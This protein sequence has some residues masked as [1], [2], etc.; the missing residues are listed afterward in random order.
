MRFFARFTIASAFFLTLTGGGLLAQSAPWWETVPEN[1]S[2]AKYFL[3]SK[4]FYQPRTYPHSRL[5]VEQYQTALEKERRKATPPSES[6]VWTPIGP[7]Q[8]FQNGIVSHWQ[9]V[10]GRA[11]ALAVDRHLGTRGHSPFTA[12]AGAAAGGIWKTDN[13]AAGTP[14]RPIGE[15]LQSLTF[16]AIA[17]DPVNTD[18]VYAGTGEARLGAGNNTYEG[19]G[20]FRSFDGGENWI[21]ITNGFGNIT[22]FAALA[23]S[24]FD[25]RV[26]LAALGSGNSSR[27]ALSNEGIW[28]SADFGIT[29]TQVIGRPDGFDVLAFPDIQDTQRNRWMFAAI[30]GSRSDSSGF[31]RSADLGATWEYIRTGLPPSDEIGR[32]QIAIAESDPSILYA[33][34]FANGIGTKVFRS[35]D[36]GSSWSQISVGVELGGFDGFKWRDQGGYDLCIAVNPENPN[37]VLLGNVELHQTLDGQNFSPVRVPPGVNSWQSP[38]HVDY[39]RIVFS[40][41]PGQVFVGSD[42]GVFVGNNILGIPSWETRNPG[43][44]TLQFY[45]LASSPFNPNHMVGG[46]QDNG[47][48]HTRDGGSTWTLSSTGDGMECF[49]D[50]AVADVVYGST[51]NGGLKRSNDGGLS[52]FSIE[53]GLPPDSIQPRAWTA[54]FFMDAVTR[55][56]LYTATDRPYF[57]NNQGG[58]WAP[59]AT[60]GLDSILGQRA[61]HNMAQSPVA[62]QNFALSSTQ[63]LYL[64]TDG[65]QTWLDRDNNLPDRWISR[66][67]WD[68]NQS[69]VL[70][71]VFS[72]F[73]TTGYIF[74][75]NDFGQNWTNL[76]GN[77]PAVPHNDLFIHPE[78]PGVLYAANDFGVYESLDDGAT[79]FRQGGRW[80]GDMPFVPVLDFSYQES[81]RLLRA[82]THGRS[83]FQTQLGNAAAAS[84]TWQGSIGTWHDPANWDP[85]GIPEFLDN[86][87]INSGNVSIDT[88]TRIAGLSLG[89]GATIS[90]TD[91]LTVTANLFWTHGSMSGA[92]VTVLD[93]GATAMLSSSAQKTLD[94]TFVN[95]GTV[96]WTEGQIGTYNDRGSV[97]LNLGRLRISGEGQFGFREGILNNL[98]TLEK[99]GTGNIIIRTEL[100][101]NR[102]EVTI[103]DGTLRL[104]AALEDSAGA[105]YLGPSADLRIQENIHYFTNSAFNGSGTI[106]LAGGQTFFEG[107]GFFLP[108]DITLRIS[109]SATLEGNAPLRIEGTLDWQQGTMRGSGTTTLAP[110]ATFLMHTS[111]QKSLH[112]NLVN[113]TVCQWSGGHIGTNTNF[114]ANFINEGTLEISGDGRFGFSAGNL[115]NHGTIMKTSPVQT[116]VSPAQFTNNGEVVV[117]QGIFELYENTNGGGNYQLA[118]GTTLLMERGTHTFNGNGIGGNGH[119]ELRN[120]GIMVVNGAGLTLPPG[121]SLVFDGFF[122]EGDGPLVIEGNF[123]WQEGT[124]RGSGTTTLAPQAT[125]LLSGSS[126]KTLYRNLVNQTVCQ[127]S[128]G[129]IGTNAGFPANFINEG[130]LEISGNGRFGFSAGNLINH[131]T[132][133]K[134][135]GTGITTMELNLIN[136]GNLAI[137]SGTI[138]IAIA[139]NNESSGTIRG[140]GILSPV[141]NSFVNEGTVSP[142]TSPGIL[143]V[144]GTYPQGPSAVLDI[145]IGGYVPGTA[146]D[147]LTISSVAQLSGLLRVRFINGFTPATG[148]TFEVMTWG[149]HTGQF[150]AIDGPA[151]V[152]IQADYR[153][154]GLMLT[155]G[156]V[157]GSAP[158]AQPDFVTLEEDRGDS[159]NVLRND[160]DP[161]GDPL[162]IIS[163]TQPVHGSLSQAGDSLLHYRPAQNFFGTDSFF[164][165]IGDGITGTAQARVLATVI[166]VND[167]PEAAALL[168][169]QSGDTLA[170][171][172]EPLLFSWGAARDVENDPVTYQLFIFEDQSDTL[173]SAISDTFAYFGG[174]GFLE[175]NRHYRWTVLSGDG[176]LVT[177]SDTAIF[178]T[179]RI[180]SLADP[181]SPLPEVLSLLQNYPNPFNPETT[182][183]FVLP[184]AERVRLAVFDILGRRVATLVNGIRPP[185][186]HSVKWDGRDDFG[187]PVASGIY[188][189]RIRAA[190]FVQTRK[191]LLVW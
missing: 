177:A 144:N 52:F 191:M 161:D 18:T 147:R 184:Q 170:S 122:L 185:G 107:P 77:L 15:D 101:F 25:R 136:Q 58:N 114:P 6:V 75:S 143:T 155:I 162:S 119:I 178:Y 31:Y 138:A 50:P 53:N 132:I 127:W 57:S 66:L 36:Y 131:G 12:Y 17:I 38:V 83:A 94:R 37:H 22:H 117:Q 156:T 72:G 82:A 174:E 51:Q 35:D 112:R 97:F 100:F 113:Q 64:S 116:R 9:S 140:S 27:G 54:P 61:V 139:L 62:P 164:Y 158:L 67:V 102:G 29:W 150:S 148:D 159:I 56:R 176:Q 59:F 74:R 126:Q 169:P 183:G 45:R 98:G 11:R 106:N 88:P 152:G 190:G 7:D 133:R 1:V 153:P 87:I 60:T 19:R 160:L 5:P 84:Y 175:L 49:Y 95:R 90:G 85:A 154:T 80:G 4:N 181:D 33:V 8:I 135:G 104:D 76:T 157:Q 151:G 187:K 14:W 121:I 73:G 86:V 70:Y 78:V 124:M 89:N 179:P 63:Y 171:L 130:T 186:W 32:M 118:A 129:H 68:P 134:T 188:F 189:Y 39:H 46:A 137:E 55:T 13:L 69:N 71:A 128:D 125:F 108:A 26:I 163:F 111:A 96:D 173:L 81:S 93:S 47:I 21:N 110:Q 40:A 16:G 41:N 23:V 91:T 2:K 123:D 65:G 44:S 180:L 146:Y 42:G 120:G 167:P 24:R 172:S 142:G 115:I 34:V 10:S 182:I 141:A 168:E 105:F 3:R 103:L 166:P 99:T 92:G 43:L 109:G 149:S 165:V 48:F 79:W 20:L 30:G 145:E 28:R